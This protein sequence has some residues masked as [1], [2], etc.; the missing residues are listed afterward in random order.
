M[1]GIFAIFILALLGCNKP[2]TNQQKA[3]NAVKEYLYIKRK[4][5]TLKTLRFT[6]LDNHQIG[7]I[8]GITVSTDSKYPPL[9]KTLWF[10]LDG[11]YT[12]VI[13]ESVN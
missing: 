7:L 3:E 9:V 1:K 13:G 4:G 10:S 11:S 8:D 5:G 2:L 12:K 6:K